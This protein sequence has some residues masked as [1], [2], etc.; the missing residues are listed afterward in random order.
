MIYLPVKPCRGCLAI[1][2][3]PQGCQEAALFQNIPYLR[4][5]TAEDLPLRQK[6]PCPTTLE[7]GTSSFRDRH[8]HSLRHRC[9]REESPAE[10]SPKKSCRSLENLTVLSKSKRLLIKK[11]FWGQNRYFQQL[12]KDALSYNPRQHFR[13]CS[14]LQ[15]Q[16]FMLHEIWITTHYRRDQGSP[17]PRDQKRLCCFG[18]FQVPSP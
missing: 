1:P 3:F 9:Y 7:T 12:L 10:N 4:G 15:V 2:S 14:R 8:C 18:I 11:A 5:L 6:R 16:H 17:L 13:S